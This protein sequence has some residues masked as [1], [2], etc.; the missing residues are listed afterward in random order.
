MNVL[1]I[2]PCHVEYG[3]LTVQVISLVSRS[4]NIV[5][6]TPWRGLFPSDIL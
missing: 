6:I 1:H 3:G 4:T 2:Q 5:Y